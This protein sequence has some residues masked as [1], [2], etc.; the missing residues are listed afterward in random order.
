MKPISLIALLLA[1]IMVMSA[2]GSPS[3][4]TPATTAAPATTTA[5]TT[6]AATEAETEATTEA[7]ATTTATS[8]AAPTTAA[9]TQ[10]TTTET[11]EPS[12]SPDVPDY[13]NEFGY[14][15]A[16][17]PMTFNAMVQIDE[18]D[19]RWSDLELMKWLEEL[20][21][22]RFN[23][24]V[25]PTKELLNEQ[26]NLQFLSGN[27]ADVIISRG[28]IDWWDEEAFGR[29]GF[30]V[31]H[32]PLID[33]WMPNAQEF[34][35]L[36]PVVKAGQTSGTGAMFGLPFY[37]FGGVGGNAHNWY[38]EAYFAQ[39]VGYDW[40]NMPSTVD[41]LK[42]MMYAIKAKLDS[43]DYMNPDPDVVVLGIQNE[44]GITTHANVMIAAFTGTLIS[45]E[46]P[47]GVPDNANVQ[48]MVEHPGYR[49]C[50]EFF[51]DLYRDGIINQDVFTIDGAAYQA[52]KVSNKYAM[53]TSSSSS[54]D[55][56]LIRD[57]FVPGHEERGFYGCA[58]VKPMTSQFND[59]PRVG[60]ESFGRMNSLN[61]T[62]KCKYP[63]VLARWSDIFFNLYYDVTDNS[64]P[65]PLM[66]FRG[67]YGVHW[68]YTDWPVNENWT[69]LDRPD[70]SADESGDTRINW[71]YSRAYLVPGWHLPTGVYIANEYAEG[72]P[73]YIAKQMTNVVQQ[74]P[75]CTTDTQFPPLARWSE[76]ETEAAATKL[77]DLETYLKES[78][79]LFMSGQIEL[80]D[81]N[82]DAFVS[83]CYAMGAGEITT[84]YQQVLNR[85]SAALAE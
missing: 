31:D 41:E 37:Y 23:Y 48:F 45:P 51:R 26:L 54:L 73:M 77:A 65:N 46:R 6:A 74:Y 47:W 85:W 61:I 29:E 78:W 19:G 12:G 27:Y 17:E 38:M 53:Y 56:E 22:V 2:C 81:S 72:S 13:M 24:D 79:G 49:A 11:P 33:R 43:G 35:S 82:W 28:N 70:G 67:Y 5:A 69:F 80:N 44:Y 66:F 68:E 8:A 21:N 83:Q 42:E 71:D 84:I 50:V 32:K 52:N 55:M 59:T 39:L 20:T 58:S 34:F 14:P 4:E 10:A 76:E 57:R 7:P 1:F 75:F 63:E 25:H 40:D 18:A 3:V 9:T 64:V 60:Y 62:D 30:F 16:K 36:Y 15:I